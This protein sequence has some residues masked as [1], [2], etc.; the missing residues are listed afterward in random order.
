MGAFDQS[1][2]FAGCDELIWMEVNRALLC[3]NVA[4]LAIGIAV[5]PGYC[6]SADELSRG[7]HFL[8]FGDFVRA[9][10]LIK[11]FY[12][13]ASGAARARAAIDLTCSSLFTE[14][15]PDTLAAA[16]EAL[17]LNSESSL[18]LT[19]YAA[20][21]FRYGDRDIART[22]FEKALAIDSQDW[23]SRLG[24]GQCL[25]FNYSL[26]V[27][28]RG[29]NY[30]ARPIQEAVLQL[31][32][33]EGGPLSGLR[34]EEKWLAIGD[35]YIVLH[36][37]QKALSCYQKALASGFPDGYPNVERERRLIKTKLV[38]A[39]LLAGDCRS[40]APYVSELLTERLSDR[41]TL[42]LIID[43][44]LSAS[45]E[46]TGSDLERSLYQSLMMRLS[47]DF[48][49][50]GYYFYKLGRAVERTNR[51]IEPQESEAGRSNDQ[52]K[53]LVELA[54]LA[55]RRGFSEGDFSAAL[56]L[57]RLLVLAGSNVEAS[58]VMRE[59]YQWALRSEPAASKIFDRR[60]AETFLTMN[61]ER[62]GDL[63]FALKNTLVGVPKV[64]VRVSR[65]RLLDWHCACKISSTHYVLA[66]SK[67]VIFAFLEPS[68]N[69]RGTIIYLPGVGKFGDQR[70]IWQRVAK[71]VSVKVLEDKEIDSLSELIEIV[72]DCRDAKYEP[73]A[74]SLQFEAP[75]LQ[76]ALKTL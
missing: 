31:A 12:R 58:S 10:P 66:M 49:H 28:E 30:Q 43:V 39:A 6:A 19:N 32:Q 17:S 70:D 25:A 42:E 72:L 33:A 3:L 15:A 36:C 8:L 76:S 20:L 62:T 7:E 50:D 71:E 41:D 55:Y 47:S 60:L 56:A 16:K 57:S 37:Y 54:L 21:Q 38:K 53:S 64:K 35:G 45:H 74:N 63:A 46:K 73:I 52:R 22:Y 27:K 13:N 14:S 34:A 11:N 75:P 44:Y 59:A 40:A 18:A 23:R 5:H 51:Q 69:G 4:L 26:T 1:H 67:S 2:S 48:P 61:K 29:I 65:A 9:Q 68:H 24:L